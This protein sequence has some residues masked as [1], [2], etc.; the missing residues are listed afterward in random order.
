M[1]LVG[2]SEAVGDAT[3]LLVGRAKSAVLIDPD[4]VQDALAGRLSPGL[5]LFIEPPSTTSL[6]SNLMAPYALVNG[7]SQAAVP[8][9]DETSTVSSTFVNSQ[10]G[11]DPVTHPS[12][13]LST[14]GFL[15]VL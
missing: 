12:P 4:H 6:P 11:E 2:E 5:A 7:H 8:K 13:S 9:Y 14:L 10:T 15:P 1:P 3:D